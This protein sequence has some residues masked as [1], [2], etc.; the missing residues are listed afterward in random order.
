MREKGPSR[1]RFR[2]MQPYTVNV[3]KKRLEWELD[4]GRVAELFGV[5]VQNTPNWYREGVGVE[6]GIDDLLM[7][8]AN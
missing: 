3:P 6:L 7:G 8:L 4:V 1:E 5:Y 2:A